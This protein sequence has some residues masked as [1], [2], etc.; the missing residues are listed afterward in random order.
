MINGAG[1]ILNNVLT[2]NGAANVLTADAGNDT[3]N[4]G[5]AN[6]S[7]IGGAGNDTYMFGR[8]YGVDTVTEND[9]AVGNSDLALFGSG[10]T[11]NQLWFTRAGNNLDV[12][13]IG[14]SDRMVMKDWYLGSQYHTEQFKT[15]DGKMLLDSRVDA[16]VSAMA[17]FAPPA[18]G[19]TTLSPEY[20][21]ALAPVLAANWQ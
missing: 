10:I 7:L 20:E 5:A 15:A 19:Q 14:T 18:V 17:S 8:G 9:A 6:D 1:N 21:T 12:S 16:L 3:L 13:I 2:G 4:G 11:T